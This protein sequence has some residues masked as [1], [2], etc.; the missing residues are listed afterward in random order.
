MHT[1]ENTLSKKHPNTQYVD[2][3]SE[4][5]RLI[6]FPPGRR[7]GMWGACCSDF[8][9]SFKRWIGLSFIFLFLSNSRGGELLFIN[10]TL[11]G[12]FL[13]ASSPTV[14]S[15]IIDYVSVRAQYCKTMYLLEK[16]RRHNVCPMLEQMQVAQFH[17][18]GE[19][20]SGAGWRVETRDRMVDRRG[21]GGSY[22]GYLCSIGFYLAWWVGRKRGHRAQ[23]NS[24]LK[25]RKGDM[26]RRTISCYTTRQSALLLCLGYCRPFIHLKYVGEGERERQFRK[27]GRKGDNLLQQYKAISYY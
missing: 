17:P 13:S 20:S 10:F 25:G 21:K 27:E 23:P 9:E 11:F 12:S 2:G 18:V 14:A 15:T 6:W 3:K 19:G 4:M 24:S 8:E 7:W 5:K 1:C 16:M 22:T 26:G